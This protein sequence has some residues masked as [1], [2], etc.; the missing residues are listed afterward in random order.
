MG[1][2]YSSFSLSNPR[3]PAGPVLEV[4]ALVDTGAVSVCLPPAL[5]AALGL[6]TLER[7]EVT[8]ADGGRH[9][10]AY[11]GPLK[12]GF[13][14][15]GCYTGAYVLGER[16][17]IGAIPLEDMDLVI[18]PARRRVSVNPA[19]PDIATAIVMQASRAGTPPAGVSAR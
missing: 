4:E 18:D 16:V 2:V 15:R 10:V 13:G 1:L 9:L 7:R 5:V 14:N 6:E 12:V 3:I 11:V 17:L 8:L 19:S